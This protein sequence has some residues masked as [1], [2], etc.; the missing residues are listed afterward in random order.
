MAHKFP[1]HAGPA[2]SPGISWIKPQAQEEYTNEQCALES[3]EAVLVP[4]ARLA[5]TIASILSQSL[6][7]LPV[8]DSGLVGSSAHFAIFLWDMQ[9]SKL[10]TRRRSERPRRDAGGISDQ[11][12]AGSRHPFERHEKLQ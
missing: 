1:I 4:A 11:F 12:A 9:G 8:E 3:V 7:A 6:P 10:W 5:T 2:F